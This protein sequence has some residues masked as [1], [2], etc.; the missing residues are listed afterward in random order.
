MINLK[1]NIGPLELLII[2]G[3]PFCNI[4]CSYCYLP[5]RLDKTKIQIEVIQRLAERLLED[6]LWTKN[7]TIVWHAGEPMAIPMEYYSKWF[8][9][10][11]KQLGN[12]VKHNFQTNAT[13]INDDWSSFIKKHK[14]SIGVSIDGP[15][16]LHDK[17]RKYRNGNGSW[18][19]AMRG[20][21]RL[22]DNDIPFQTISVIDSGGLI[23]VDALYEFFKSIKPI[24]VGFNIDEEEGVNELS[25]FASKS[26]DLDIK[27]A[28]FWRKLNQ[29]DYENNQPFRLRELVT[30]RRKV[31]LAATNKNRFFFTQLTG[32]YRII[33]VDAKGN[34]STFAPD[35]LGQ[36]HEKY[37]DF[38]I[39]NVFD[40]SFMDAIKTLKFKNLYS[41]ILDGMLKCKNDCDFY[42]YC[43]E[44]APSNKLYEN[45]TFKSTETAY[46]KYIKQTSLLEVIDHFDQSIPK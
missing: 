14:I 46:C 38:I 13:L 19:A 11:T 30:A 41:D 26:K 3:S 15:E 27:V 34:F 33:S 35:L 25:S 7:T 16:F 1:T 6:N 43:G 10:L 29:L 40:T 4:D 22:I 2:Q 32:V 39:G 21:K 23:Y 45:G 44:G 17:Y 5:N 9:V 20:I 37:S 8:E 12:N 36:K 24:S 18:S 31:K 42:K 28:L